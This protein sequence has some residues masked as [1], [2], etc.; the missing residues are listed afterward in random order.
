MK[1]A[2][3]KIADVQGGYPFR[4]SVPEDSGGS[5]FA[6]Q[7][8][9]VSLD[10]A[11]AWDALV[12]TDITGRRDTDW[13]RPGDVLFVA[14]GTRN[15]ALCLGEVPV[16][17][18]CSPNFFLLR[19]KSAAEVLPEFL[20]WQINQ[21]PAQRY[22]RQTAEGSDQLSIRRGTLEELPI[23]LSPLAQQQHVVALASLALRER[24]LHEALIEN[25]ERQLRALAQ[26]LLEE[27][28]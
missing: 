4:G 20:A 8:K 24:T 11:V 14:R 16:P 1:T 7:M 2:L 13:L 26:R 19:E 28:K 3:R 9:D 17:A 21:Q 27:T 23:T 12:R 6:V 18:V 5:A 22:L 15:F 10:G 25:R